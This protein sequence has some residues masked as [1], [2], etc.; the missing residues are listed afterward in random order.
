MLSWQ[1]S[2]RTIALG[3]PLVMGILN[4]TPDSFSD[5]GRFNAPDAASRRIEQMIADGADIIDIG[6]ESTR[7]GSEQVDADEEIRRVIPAIGSALHFDVPVSVDTSK[8]SVARAAI[9]AGAEIINDISGL[10]FDGDM[11]AAAAETGAGLVLMHSRGDFADMH[12]QPAVA[13]IFDEVCSGLTASVE[14]AEAAGIVSEKIVL[15]V[16]IGFGKTLEQNLELLARHAGIARGFD[17]IPFL[18]G[19]SRKSFIGKILGD[20]S[21]EK[22]LAGSLAAALYAVERGAAIVRTHDVKETADALR[23]HHAISQSEPNS[24]RS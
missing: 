19:V 6:G 23:I 14:K 8:S 18:I 9:D 5:G 2:R 24:V 13:N 7:P 20:A 4:V 3:R 22:R 1:T 21:P 16:G 15:D 11:A 17:G 10:R 12:S